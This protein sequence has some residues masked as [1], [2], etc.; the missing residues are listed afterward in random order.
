MSTPPSITYR[1]PTVPE[2]TWN[3][4]PTS[5]AGSVGKTVPPSMSSGNF[6]YT[7]TT[8]TPPPNTTVSPILYT[9]IGGLSRK[10]RKGMGP[11]LL[12]LLLLHLM[13]RIIIIIILPTTTHLCA[14]IFP[15]PHTEIRKTTPAPTRTYPSISVTSEPS[16]IPFTTP[17]ETNT[18]ANHSSMSV[19]PALFPEASKTHTL[20]NRGR[21]TTV[22]TDTVP[23]WMSHTPSS[24]YTISRDHTKSSSRDR[25]IR[26]EPQKR[27]RNATLYPSK[28]K[29]NPY[30]GGCKF[31]W[32]KSACKQPRSC[33]VLSEHSF[34]YI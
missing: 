20:H 26:R 30:N 28:G 19:P 25:E 18:T 3:N 15:E 22:G 31:L 13:E 12:L 11:I 21:V 14:C 24:S 29:P 1:I 27:S 6:T 9:G 32:N 33:S 17:S 5:P 34:S 8:P 16:D 2:D 10:F 4:A 23:P 7:S